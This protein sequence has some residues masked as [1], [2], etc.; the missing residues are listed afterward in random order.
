MS[1][2]RCVRVHFILLAQIQEFNAQNDWRD[3]SSPPSRNLIKAE[4][5][6][7]YELSLFPS[8][9]R[10]P[11]EPFPLE[12]LTR[13]PVFKPNPL[14]FHF[15]SPYNTDLNKFCEKVMVGRSTNEIAY[16]SPD[17][18]KFGPFCSP[19]TIVWLMIPGHSWKSVVQELQFWAFRGMRDGNKTAK[20]QLYRN[21][22]AFECFET[23][24][25]AVNKTYDWIFSLKS[26]SQMDIMS[27]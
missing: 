5:P 8:R 26:N 17:N 4:K 22:Q 25:L 7:V 20:N 14:W 16:L 21:N 15:P 27:P 12:K 9:I 2:F 18:I 3:G 19:N 10:A 6:R 24:I 1:H 23:V 11:Q 13:E